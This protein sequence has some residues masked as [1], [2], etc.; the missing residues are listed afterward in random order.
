MIRAEDRTPQ[1]KPA[2]VPVPS[3]EPAGKRVKFL[4]F[5]LDGDKMAP[6]GTLDVLASSLPLYT[7]AIEQVA[8]TQPDAVVELGRP[9]TRL[10]VTEVDK[11]DPDFV[12]T[13][14]DCFE[15]GEVI[16]VPLFVAF[17]CQKFPKF[18]APLVRH[19]IDKL[20]QPCKKGGYTVRSLSAFLN[21]LKGP[22][23]KDFHALAEAHVAWA[24]A[25]R[26]TPF[27]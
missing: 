20:N 3:A 5:T 15:V 4:M 10:I 24:T 23:G 6:F 19:Y 11:K 22:A 8:D 17:I 14:D 7:D 16:T 27:Q 25:N 26:V 12:G 9:G 13:S 1:A 2:T 21:D 18:S